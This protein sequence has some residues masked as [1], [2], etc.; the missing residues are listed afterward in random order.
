LPSKEGTG[1]FANNF[2]CKPCWLEWY[3][4]TYPVT[5]HLVEEDGDSRVVCTN[6]AG[7]EISKT[8]GDLSRDNVENLRCCLKRCIDSANEVTTE[9]RLAKNWRP[10]EQSEFQEYYGNEWEDQWN[11]AARIPN[12]KLVLLGVGGDTLAPVCTVKPEETG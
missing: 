7:K 1:D 12:F 11:T 9:K 5:L 8:A 10:Y 6:L 4:T 3:A 2:F